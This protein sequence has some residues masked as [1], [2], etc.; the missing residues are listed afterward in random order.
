MYIY[1]FIYFKF[2]ASLF[3]W[4]D[5]NFVISIVD[6]IGLVCDQESGVRDLNHDQT[7]R[8]QVRI[9]VWSSIAE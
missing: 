5:E 8:Y 9:T 1:I 3:I 4:H 2:V 6:Q 7:N